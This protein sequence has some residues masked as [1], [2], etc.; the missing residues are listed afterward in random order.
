MLFSSRQCLGQ[1]FGFLD[2]DPQ[3]YA[4]PRI[5]I[6][7]AKY[8]PKTAKKKIYFQNPNLNYLKR[9]DYENF[10]ISEWFFKI[11][12]KNKLQK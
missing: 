9:R 2:P 11:Q 4:D 10:I 1:N 5:R 12:H 7:G 3:K 6:Q 8:Q